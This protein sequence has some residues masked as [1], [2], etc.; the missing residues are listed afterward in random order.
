MGLQMRKA[1]AVTRARLGKHLNL[2][3]RRVFLV[4]DILNPPKPV[5]PEM[6]RIL[7]VILRILAFGFETDVLVRHIVRRQE[8]FDQPAH[9]I[10]GVVRRKPQQPP[11]WVVVVDEPRRKEQREGCDHNLQNL[12]PV[13]PFV[14]VDRLGNYTSVFVFTDEDHEPQ[15]HH[16]EL[17]DRDVLVEDNPHTSSD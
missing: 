10:H 6:T 8:D 2:P 12:M 13:T 16:P 9:H 5:I 1:P 3:F 14:T 17:S 15:R 4:G 11:P 7:G